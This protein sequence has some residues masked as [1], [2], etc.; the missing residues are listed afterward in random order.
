MDDKIITISGKADGNRLDS[1][2]L[3]ERIQE[4]VADGNRHLKVQAYGQHGIG[5]RLWRAGD[6]PVHVK[7]EWAFR[8][9]AGL[10]GI[11]EY[12]D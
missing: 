11:S 9:A 3:E 5:G 10:H 4:A 8:T 7:V 6:D 2:I 1:R 12:G